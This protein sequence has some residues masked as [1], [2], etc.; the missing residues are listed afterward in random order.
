APLPSPLHAL[1]GILRYRLLSRGE[2]AG[3]LS[4]GMRLM[5]MRR[6]GDDRLRDWTL[7][8]L[9]IALGQSANARQSF[10]DPIAVATLNESPER[11]AAAPFA[12]VLARAF[13]GSRR[14]SQFVLSRVGLSE[15]YTSDARR[16]I[17]AR[18]GCI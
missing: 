14:D 11:A 6:R 12:E 9:L 8:R 2:R 4:A 16:F 5:V 15:L 10:W 18:G 13:F 1:V 3:A 7:A 17:E